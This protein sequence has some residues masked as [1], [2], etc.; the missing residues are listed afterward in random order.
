MND[1]IFL[2]E[3][4]IF[5]FF[6]YRHNL[7]SI[8]CEECT[9]KLIYHFSS[10]LSYVHNEVEEKE[11]E[12]EEKDMDAINTSYVPISKFCHSKLSLGRVVVSPLFHTPHFSTLVQQLKESSFPKSHF[13]TLDD[14]EKQEGEN[15][16]KSD[17][18]DHLVELW[19]VNSSYFQSLFQHQISQYQLSNIE[20]NRR[21]DSDFSLRVESKV[22][23]FVEYLINPT[24][25]FKH[26]PLSQSALLSSKNTKRTSNYQSNAPPPPSEKILIFN[27]LEMRLC[28]MNPSPKQTI[29][30][31]FLFLFIS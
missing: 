6:W 14:N 7:A 24:T 22:R 20:S 9:R 12:E 21:R 8:M 26:S 11:K 17:E 19:K 29:M 15:K 25:V 10:F 5:N 18:N 4:F 13:S 23:D 2:L 3:S 1:S 16:K 31:V 28:W 27:P 30:K